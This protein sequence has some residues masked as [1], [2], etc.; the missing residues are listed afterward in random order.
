[1][2]L[3]VDD[4]RKLDTL[5]TKAKNEARRE[6]EAAAGADFLRALSIDGFRAQ[7]RVSR[8]TQAKLDRAAGLC[9]LSDRVG[10]ALDD[11]LVAA[12][13]GGT[14]YPAARERVREREQWAA[15]DP[16]ERPF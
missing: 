12:D 1:M 4:L 8:A 14:L 3:S 5:A 9:A 11:Q 16:P 6:A 15:A 10:A 13:P 7:P 2:S